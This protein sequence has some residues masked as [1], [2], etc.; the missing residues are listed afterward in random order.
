VITATAQIRTA[1]H[2]TANLI[3]LLLI[4]KLLK[5]GGQ[6]SMDFWQVPG[7]TA[8][9]QKFPPRVQN[10]YLIIQTPQ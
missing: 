1:Y 3:A 9:L 7:K 8:V 2:I 5:Q 10:I 6:G 4:E